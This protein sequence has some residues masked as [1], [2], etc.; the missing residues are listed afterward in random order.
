MDATKSLELSPRKSRL[1]SRAIAKALGAYQV[2][3]VSSPLDGL[4]ILAEANAKA[5]GKAKRL[6][7]RARRDKKARG[8]V[9][10]Q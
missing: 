3:S 1:D 7:G 8:G 5:R 9:K 4:K 6:G 10:R 2:V